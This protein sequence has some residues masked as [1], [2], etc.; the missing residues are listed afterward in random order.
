[1]TT[2]RKTWW[3]AIG[4]EKIGPCSGSELIELVAQGKLFPETL[5][6]KQGM[7]NWVPASR[8]KG[9]WQNPPAVPPQQPLQ[10]TTPPPFAASVP[11]SS[12][13][14]DAF[15]THDN[16][17][18][19]SQPQFSDSLSAQPDWGDEYEEE[20]QPPKP[21][22]FKEAVTRCFKKYSVFSGRASRAEYWYFVLFNILINTPL[23][24]LMTFTG[25]KDSP[26]SLVSDLIGLALLVPNVAVA[27]RR[28]HDIGRS[29]WW[30]LIAF[31]GIG[32]FVLLYWAVKEGDE[33]ANEYGYL[34]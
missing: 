23:I 8:I 7:P 21:L 4:Q 12:P 17:N 13:H 33:G 30:Q 32:V 20:P 24:I 29:G 22:T 28:L 31:T 25:G 3:Y 1:M 2:S 19:S 9:L 16:N 27:T 18:A 10:S 6:W 11:A 34:E 14:A 5:V 26:F 15:G